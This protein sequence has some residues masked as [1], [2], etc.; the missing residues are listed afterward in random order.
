M[1]SVDGGVSYVSNSNGPDV[2]TYGGYVQLIASTNFDGSGLYIWPSCN[3]GN[4]YFDAMKFAIGAA[5]SEVDIVKD[6]PSRW[7]SGGNNIRAIF[8]PTKVPKG[9]RISMAGTNAG[10]VACYVVG[11]GVQV[12]NSG[13]LATVYG[14]T[15][16]GSTSHSVVVQAGSSAGTKGSWTEIT[17][18]CARM[19][20][21]YVLVSL[22]ST[23]VV[24]SN[25][26]YIDIAVGGAGS[27]VA[28]QSD[29]FYRYDYTSD[30]CVFQLP[31]SIPAGTRISARISSSTANDQLE[32][33]IL[34]LG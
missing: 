31:L 8:L 7:Y 2:G 17:A 23:G 33:A 1:Q 25:V 13:L 24:A 6:L 4:G 26:D 34:G 29:M 14:V 18:S 28:V 11:G 16:S 10:S 3:G 19:V 12:A 30:T 5:G 21:G 27:E 15:L 9:S 20:T 32:L 22:S